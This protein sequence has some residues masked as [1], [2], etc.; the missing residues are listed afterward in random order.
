MNL[1]FLRSSNYPKGIHR[2][3][4]RR[5]VFKGL[6]VKGL[7]VSYNVPPNPKHWFGLVREHE[8]DADD[9]DGEGDIK[10]V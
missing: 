7:K 9:D 6:G 2:P 5:D 10:E 3:Q 4:I 8:Q 1:F